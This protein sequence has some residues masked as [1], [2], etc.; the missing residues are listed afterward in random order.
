MDWVDYLR[1]L[2]HRWK[3]VAITLLIALAAAW[4]TTSVGPTPTGDTGSLFRA[5]TVLLNAGTVE[6]LGVT[7]LETVG[8]LVTVGQ[9][10]KDVAEA[11]RTSET[12]QSLAN[13]VTTET[14]VRTGVVRISAIAPTKERAELLSKT[15]ADQLIAYLVLRKSNSFG[16]QNQVL[17]DELAK[18]E[19]DIRTLDRLVNERTGAEQAIYATQRNAKISSYGFTYDAF[20]RLANNQAQP[21]QLEVLQAGEGLPVAR[22]GFTAPRSRGG[23]LALAAILGLLAGAA[24]ALV[25]ERLDTR[26]RTKDEAEEAFALPVLGEVPQFHHAKSYGIETVANPSS[27]TTHN[28][29]LLRG[30]LVQEARLQSGFQGNGEGRFSGVFLVTSASPGDGKTTVVANLAP[31]FTE[32]G[33]SVL[34]LSCDFRRPEVHKYYRVSNARGLVDAI[35]A[36]DGWRILEG[37][38]FR[39]PVKDVR[40][41]PSGP[42]PQNPGE[43]M[44]SDWMR[45]VLREARRSADV[46]LIDTPPILAA[47]DASHLLSQVD[48][49]IIVSRA[50][51]ASA[52][53]AQ[54]TTEMVRRLGGTIL[55][56]VL[57][58]V[59][60]G[61]VMSRGYYEYTGDR[62]PSRLGRLVHRARRPKP[63]KPQVPAGPN[64]QK[65]DLTEPKA[66]AETPPAPTA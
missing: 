51:K 53:V 48:G 7:N 28:F 14:D 8:Q 31:V 46:V 1:V 22:G 55:G 65:I 40:L 5:T 41:V 38:S 56:L 35:K 37:M 45:E 39:T 9:V 60:N 43:L 50:G 20:N 17:K 59:R 6:A 32:I 62:P 34:I 58:G 29:R 26:I 25:L 63:F 30:G 23:R 52:E 57:N 13:K 15:F 64:G 18:L 49:V 4:V 47:S 61:S 12:P 3:V 36:A 2:R 24:V 42:V 11:L 19:R 16:F 33:L 21:V 27:A 66:P 10:P 44:S 54:R